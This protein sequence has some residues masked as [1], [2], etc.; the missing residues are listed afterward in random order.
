MAQANVNFN[1]LMQ[2]GRISL[3]AGRRKEAH[4]LWKQ[5][6][7]LEPYNEQV[8]LSLLEAVDDDEDKRVCLQN[9]LQINSLNVQAR[10]ELNRLE[11]KIERIELQTQEMARVQQDE[12]K[13]R[14]LVLLRAVMLGLAVGLSGVVFAIVISIL[15]YN[16]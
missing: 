5:A 1:D 6:A 10:R 8:W 3:S 4:D 2:A 15:L 11:A 9:I 12:R 13:R 14:R 7:A 16:R